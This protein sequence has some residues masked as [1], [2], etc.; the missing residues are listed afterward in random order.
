LKRFFKITAGSILVLFFVTLHAVFADVAVSGKL[1]YTADSMSVYDMSVSTGGGSQKRKVYIIHNGI[2][3]PKKIIWLFHG[4]KPNG[5]PYKQSPAAFI[6]NWGLIKLCKENG[7]L[8]I[9]PDMGTSLYQLSQLNDSTKLSDMR[10]LKELYNDIVFKN[11]RNVPIILAGVSTGVEG[12]I[13]FSTIIENVESI[14]ALSGTYDFMSLDSSGGEF[15]IHEQAFG[16]NQ[17]V[18]FNENPVEILRRSVRLKLYLFCEEYSIYN[19]QARSLGNLRLT[20]L[21]IDERFDLGRGFTHS[22]QFWGN[23]RVVQAIKEIMTR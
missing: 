3:N 18:W 6:E 4:Y 21:D 5:D 10:Y 9:A 19:A 22:W 20:N 7:Y 16:N 2:K 8:C 13:K 11:H 1:L 17:S 15:R 14:I 23:R 12:A